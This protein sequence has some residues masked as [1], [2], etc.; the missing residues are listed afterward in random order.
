M[1]RIVEF[2]LKC[3]R[4]RFFYLYLFFILLL[5]IYCESWFRKKEKTNYI[6]RLFS[7]FN[8]TEN[9]NVITPRALV[10][11]QAL[12]HKLKK[13]KTNR[14]NTERNLMKNSR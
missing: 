11:K 3:P 9:K 12:L 7:F 4:L 6:F 2:K 10:L 5:F 14:H 8:N 1:K 13:I